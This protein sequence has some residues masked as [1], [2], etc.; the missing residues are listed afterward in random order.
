MSGDAWLAQQLQQ[1]DG[2]QAREVV[3]EDL[4]QAGQQA[5][6]AL[7]SKGLAG[8]RGNTECRKTPG[9]GPSAAPRRLPR[10][11][12]PPSRATAPRDPRAGAVPEPVR[13]PPGPGRGWRGAAGKPRSLPRHQKAATG[14]CRAAPRP[15]GGRAVRRATIRAPMVRRRRPRVLD[16]PGPGAT[17]VRGVRRGGRRRASGPGSHPA[18]PPGA[19]LPLPGGACPSG[20]PPCS[21]SSPMATFCSISPRAWR[22][23]SHLG[24]KGSVGGRRLP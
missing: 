4:E 8:G 10:P 14:V 7:R 13:A 12:A 16:P 11:R 1:F 9:P 6:R 20:R 18:S 21:T 23:G 3:I 5:A 19:P 22:R 15:S 2:A 24:S 17:A